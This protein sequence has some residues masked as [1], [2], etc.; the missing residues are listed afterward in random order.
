MH[1]GQTADPLNRYSKALKVISGKRG[2]TD[3]DFEEMAKIEWYASLYVSDGKIVIPDTVLEATF[4]AGA[5]KSKLGKQAEAG[6]FVN[7]HATLAFD[8]DDL[9]IDELFERDE[10]RHCCAVRVQ[11][12]KVMRT[13]SIFKN[14]ATVVDIRFD[15][16]L[17]N[18]SQVVRAAEDAGQQAGLCDWRPKFGRFE[19]TSGI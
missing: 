13:R 9:S 19:I 15:D 5:R 14:W 17:L 11:R 16:N 6:L 4:L 18:E 3:A 1:N 7:G 12:N 10:N 8:G 2:K